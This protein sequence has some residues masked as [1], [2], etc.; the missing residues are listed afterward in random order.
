MPR[1]IWKGSISFG[2]VN[3][4]V[5]LYSGEKPDELSFSMLDRRDFAP[6]GYRRYN[7]Q[8]NKPVEWSDIV[9]GYEYADGEYVALSADDF[10]R[11][12]VES[13]QTIELIDFVEQAGIDSVFYDKPYYL[14][15]GK[16]GAKGYALLR[17]ALRKSGRVGIATLV[18]RTRQ[19]LAALIP[20]DDALVLNVLRFAHELRDS[21]ELQLP[22]TDLKSLK[23]TARE[24]GMA[25]R[26]IDEMTTG[27]DPASY[28]DEY[29]DDLLRLIEKKIKAGEAHRLEEGEVEAPASASNVVDMM[30]LLKKSLESRSKSPP[31]PKKGRK[32]QARKKAKSSAKRS[33]KK[34][35]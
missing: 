4:P 29:R 11:A 27:W 31:R 12:N 17:E 24:V 2:L 20:M 13:T 10:K 3:V 34:R 9:K 33:S 14:E 25:E 22:E 6:V 28:R 16:Q 32:T 26:L 19:R 8:T 30:A 21:T 35:A 7:K 5:S 23:V 15:P 1:A 18:L